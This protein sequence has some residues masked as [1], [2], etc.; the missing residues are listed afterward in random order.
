VKYEGKNRVSG[1]DFRRIMFQKQEE[2]LGQLN[3]SWQRR[4]E[5]E[6]RL[7]LA[8]HPFNDAL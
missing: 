4:E 6:H 7:V 3:E 5:E 2:L 1:Q 8:K